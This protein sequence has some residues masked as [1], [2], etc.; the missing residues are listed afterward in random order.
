MASMSCTLIV[1]LLMIALQPAPSHAS[2]C[3]RFGSG[4]AAVQQAP[5]QHVIAH[6]L[7]QAGDKDFITLA[8]QLMASLD[9]IFFDPIPYLA[10][11]ARNPRH[12]QRG[13]L[14][15]GDP[16][17]DVSHGV[18]RYTG[19]QYC[20][21]PSTMPLH[22]YAAE[23]QANAEELVESLTDTETEAL[24]A[25][26]LA[27]GLSRWIDWRDAQRKRV[28]A[29]VSAA[30]SARNKQRQWQNDRLPLVLAGYAHCMEAADLLTEAS[31]LQPGSSYRAMAAAAG[32]AYGRLIDQDQEWP[33]WPWGDPD[34][35]DDPEFS[36]R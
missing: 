28:A 33:D 17:G 30:P 2:P 13:Q 35:F 29:F 23:C 14:L 21:G 22:R 4:W 18:H 6:G 9:Q 15:W 11:R 12:P 10:I 5:H 20:T 19:S 8:S 32:L 16:F 24:Y 26:L 3:L 7:G 34:P 1:C 36:E 25:W 31:R 27:L